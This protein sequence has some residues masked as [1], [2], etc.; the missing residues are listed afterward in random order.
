MDKKPIGTIAL[1]TLEIKFRLGENVLVCSPANG[2]EEIQKM[3]ILILT[4]KKLTIQQVL[5]YHVQ[6]ILL[7]IGESPICFNNVEALKHY[8]DNLSMSLMDKLE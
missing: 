6:K 7:P 5:F 4:E 8:P 1:W 3:F 2:L